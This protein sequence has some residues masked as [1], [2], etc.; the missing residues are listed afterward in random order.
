[1]SCH[2]SSSLRHVVLT[3]CR[4]CRIWFSWINPIFWTVYGLIMS[5]ID[6]LTTPVTLQDGSVVTPYDAALITFGYQ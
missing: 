2:R 5:Q 6:N 4:P 1:M 3:L